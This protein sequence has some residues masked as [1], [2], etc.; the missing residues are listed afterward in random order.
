MFQV[1]RYTRYTLQNRRVENLEDELQRLRALNK[2]LKEE[3]KSWI[4]QELISTEYE[5]LRLAYIILQRLVKEKYKY[6]VKHRG[7][8]TR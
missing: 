5:T 2:M 3:G 7:L 8:A 1:I 6:G 4:V